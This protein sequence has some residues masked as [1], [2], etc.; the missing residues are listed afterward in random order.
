MKIHADKLY[1]ADMRETPAGVHSEFIERG[2]RSRARAFD[3]SLS[4]Q[5]GHDRHGIKRCY[6]RNTGRSGGAGDWDRAAT[7]VEW[8]DWICELFRRDPK[9]IIGQYDGATDFVAQ[10]A[11]AAPYR[12]ERENAGAHAERW[13]EEIANS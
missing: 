10:T 4:A 8:G 7:W 6:A 11:A 5:H 3:V 2:S 13:A 1:A 9:A 12:P